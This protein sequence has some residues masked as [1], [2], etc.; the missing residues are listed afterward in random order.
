MKRAILRTLILVILTFLILLAFDRKR[1]A[2]NKAEAVEP[3]VNTRH[4][5]LNLASRETKSETEV[6]AAVGMARIKA[7]KAAAQAQLDG[8]IKKSHAL[9][10]L[11]RA[12]LDAERQ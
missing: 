1:T 3:S 8:D 7:K 4:D 6:D 10:A 12:I 9:A 11:E 5:A 2:S